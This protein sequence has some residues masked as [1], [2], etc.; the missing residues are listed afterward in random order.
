MGQF[1]EQSGTAEGE[2]GSRGFAQCYGE[3][4]AVRYGSGAE[5]FE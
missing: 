5:W 1:E 4:V 2:A 3:D